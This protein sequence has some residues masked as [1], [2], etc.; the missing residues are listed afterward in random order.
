MCDEAWQELQAIRGADRPTKNDEVISLLHDKFFLPTLCAV[1]V[2]RFLEA[3]DKRLFNSS[4]CDHLG[5][6]ALNFLQKLFP[7]EK[8]ALIDG[9]V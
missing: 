5:P 2:A 8:A 4:D 3:K 9:P 1:Q 6:N 7:D